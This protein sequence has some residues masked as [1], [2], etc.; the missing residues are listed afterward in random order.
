MYICCVVWTVV[1]QSSGGLSKDDIENMVRNAEKHAEDDRRKKVRHNIHWNYNTASEVY[2]KSKVRLINY[3]FIK[4][5]PFIRFV[6]F[7]ATTAAFI[8][9]TVHHQVS[10]RRTVSSHRCVEVGRTP[11]LGSSTLRRGTARF[12]SAGVCLERLVSK[13]TYNA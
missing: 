2:K 7:L 4:L 12:F 11:R 8:R 1:I 6:D 13:I 3:K 5:Q 10:T 9:M